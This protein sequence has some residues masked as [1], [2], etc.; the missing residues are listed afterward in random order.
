MDPLEKEFHEDM[1]QIYKLVLKKRLPLKGFLHLVID[2]GGVS[3]AHD[4]IAKPDDLT[5]QALGLNKLR[6]RNLL[7]LSVEYL[8]LYKDG[9]KY[10]KLF[11]PEELDECRKR[12]K[13]R[14]LV[15]E[16]QI[17]EGVKR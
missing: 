2:K 10:N 12:L 1:V 9:G 7:Y 17:D 4:L 6:D 3:T 16:T 5:D 14:G 15:Q 11:T 13:E 8:V